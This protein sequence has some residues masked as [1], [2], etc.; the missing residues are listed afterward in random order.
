MRSNAKKVRLSPSATRSDNSQ[1]SDKRQISSCNDFLCDRTVEFMESGDTRNIVAVELAEQSMYFE[2]LVRYH[3]GRGVIHL[4]EF[5]RPCFDDVIEYIRSGRVELTEENVYDMFVAADYLLVS[6][7]KKKSCN[8][9][10][11]IIKKPSYAVS[12]WVT[13][14]KFNWPELRTMAY[15]EILKNFEHIWK[16]DEFLELNKNDIKDII[17]NDQLNCKREINLVDAITAWMTAKP[18]SRQSF[19]LELLKCLRLGLLNYNELLLLREK[20]IV[21]STKAYVDILENWSPSSKEKSTILS[22]QGVLRMMSPR[23]PH[24]VR[25]F[26]YIFYRS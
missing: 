3:K 7:L 24:D 14:Q 9:I 19:S 1:K 17:M 10:Q 18:E 16:T 22:P 23:F 8:F 21:K 20:T 15:E 5:L 4:P 12:L 2:R 11:E 25:Y 13:C 26:I 6:S